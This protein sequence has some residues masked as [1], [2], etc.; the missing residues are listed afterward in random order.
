[1][2]IFWVK[3]SFSNLLSCIFT[4]TTKTLTLVIGCRG[5]IGIK[6]LLHLD[7]TLTWVAWVGNKPNMR[8]SVTVRGSLLKDY[9]YNRV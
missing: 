4:Q 1:M 5:P 6:L 9:N 8:A 7:L 3:Q 2:V